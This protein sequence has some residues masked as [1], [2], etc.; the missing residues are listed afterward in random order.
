[1]LKSFLPWILYSIFYGNNPEQLMLAIGVALVS[2]LIFDWKDLK[3]GFIL[4][5]CTFIYFLALLIFVSLYH[6]IWLEKN[7]WLVSNLMLA[8]IAF[9]SVLIKKPFTIQYAK[10]KIPEIY[11]NNPLFIEINH[12]LT[13]I[14]GAIFLFTALTNYLHADV[15]KLHGV[16]YFIV[17]NIGWVIGAYVSKKFPDYWK[18]RKLSH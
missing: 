2:S 11:W 16:L 10:Q 12:I 1:M 18:K 8:A 4:T 14:W 17:N 3:A 7:M 5:R 13:M 9:G 6:S 15:L